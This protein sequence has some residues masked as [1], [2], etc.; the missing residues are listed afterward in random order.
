VLPLDPQTC[1]IVRVLLGACSSSLPRSSVD[2]WLRLAIQTENQGAAGVKL[3]K[4][5]DF[6]NRLCGKNRCTTVKNGVSLYRDSRHL[7]VDGALTL[8]GTFQRAIVTHA[9]PRK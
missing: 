7:S 4:T 8:T 2:N 9:I 3:V 5:I 1:A 6:E